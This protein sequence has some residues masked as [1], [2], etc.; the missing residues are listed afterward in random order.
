MPHLPIL[1]ICST[2]DGDGKG[3]GGGITTS[4]FGGEWTSSN[5]GDLTVTK[6]EGQNQFTLVFDPGTTKY[7]YTLSYTGSIAEVIQDN[8]PDNPLGKGVPFT[9]TGKQTEG[10]L[11]L[12]DSQ[13][14]QWGLFRENGTVYPSLDTSRAGPA[15][16]LLIK[17]PGKSYEKLHVYYE[18]ESV[19]SPITIGGKKH[20]GDLAFS[21]HTN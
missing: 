11:S 19:S 15:G 7:E 9:S 14:S 16:Y 17:D 21:K 10:T 6:V 1:C 13:Y 2:D 12:T 8:N 5:R 3:G 4:S 18:D 20:F